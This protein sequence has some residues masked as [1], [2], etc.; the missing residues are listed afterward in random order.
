M[1]NFGS[2]LS[3]YGLMAQGAEASNKMARDAEF[4]AQRLEAAKQ[5]NTLS[6][7]RVQEGQMGLEDMTRQRGEA[8]SIRR[9]GVSGSFLDMAKAAKAVGRLEEAGKYEKLYAA[10]DDEGFRRM[11]DVALRKPQPGYRPDIGEEFNRYGNVKVDPQS[12]TLDTNGNL[13][14]QGKSG[15]RESLNVGVTAERMGM[16]KPPEMKTVP[17]GG[18]GVIFQPGQPIKTIDTPKTFADPAPHTVK[19]YNAEGQVISERLVDSR[20]GRDIAQSGS[21][22][23]GSNAP[24]IV[25]H[26]PVLDDITKNLLLLP[27]MSTTDMTDPLSPK[28]K[29]TAEGQKRSMIAEQLYLANRD[30]A[31]QTIIDIATKGEP[32]WRIEGGKRTGVIRY[33]GQEFPL[34]T[35]GGPQAVQPPK[36]KAKD[37]T[38]LAK[39]AKEKETKKESPGLDA[40]QTTPKTKP[41]MALSE[42]Q[43]PPA[44]ASPRNRAYMKWRETYG[45]AWD[46]LTAREKAGVV[47]RSSTVTRGA[48]PA[49]RT[50]GIETAGH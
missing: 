1:A 25:K 32:M 36:P 8:E 42:I 19:T 34:K 44:P 9:A 24:N 20:T 30:I 16:V 14:W 13:S 46:A 27:G 28:V 15:Q 5:A 49:Q 2:F 39:E 50:F 18:R 31:P 47:S 45:E 7:Q 48:A 40:V 26:R 11:L 21:V 23:D 43:P 4:E 12:V 3:N 6:G 29:P 35:P 17:A 10:L 38:D 22:P 33:N 41:R 37:Q